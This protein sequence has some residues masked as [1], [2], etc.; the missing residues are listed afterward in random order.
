MSGD[1][2]KRGGGSTWITGTYDPELNLVYWG[3][4]NP[5]PDMDGDVRLGDNLYSCSL[6]ALDADTGKLKWHYQM[7]PHDVHDWDAVADPVP[8]DI[9][10]DGRKVKAVV[11]ANRNGF[12]YALDRANG[13]LLYA[14]AYTKV[15]WAD[16]IGPD[17]RPILISGHEP[18][19]EGTH[20]CPGMGGGHNWQGTAYS[21]QTQLYY[22]TSSEHCMPYYKTKQDFVPGL[23]VSW[24][25]KIRQARSMSATRPSR[26]SRWGW[27][28]SNTSSRG[29]RGRW[30]SWPW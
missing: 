21:P 7:T 27:R 14:K 8:M 9:D 26:P 28:L 11:Q 25:A 6:V 2:W 19:D 24:W 10:I 3:T 15:T 18:S 4:G 29:R 16:G 1:G 5:G 22:F 30:N 13:K 23:A 12:L 17:G 20:T